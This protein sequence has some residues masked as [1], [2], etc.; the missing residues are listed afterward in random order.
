MISDVCA[1]VQHYGI[2][3]QYRSKVRDKPPLENSLHGDYPIN[4]FVW[5]EFEE[6]TVRGSM[7]ECF[8]ALLKIL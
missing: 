6:K 4:I 7:N 1:N 5:P 3:R 8:C 2:A